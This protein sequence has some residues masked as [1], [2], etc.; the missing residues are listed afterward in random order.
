MRGLSVWGYVSQK[1]A[2]KHCLGHRWKSKL[3][4]GESGTVGVSGGLH[5]CWAGAVW[6]QAGQGRQQASQTPAVG[7]GGTASE[8]HDLG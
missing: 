4:G 1:T 8:L 7:S 2:R 5:A 3:F 6:G